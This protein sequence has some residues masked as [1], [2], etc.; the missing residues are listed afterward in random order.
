[1]IKTRE[2]LAKVEDELDSTMSD[3]S[4]KCSESRIFCESFACSLMTV[5]GTTS[6]RCKL[7][8]DPIE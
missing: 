3:Q 1:M 2:K 6:E 8:F 7:L 4:F 5:R